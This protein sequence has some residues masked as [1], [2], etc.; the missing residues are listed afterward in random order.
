MRS[1]NSNG[2]AIL[3]MVTFVGVGCSASDPNARSRRANGSNRP[4]VAPDRV[5]LGSV[6]AGKTASKSISVSNPTTAP[7]DFQVEVDCDCLHVKPRVAV[8]QP[9]ETILLSIR[10]DS[11]E[12]PDFRGSLSI[13]VRG[14]DKRSREV[15][16]SKLDIIV[17]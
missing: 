16:R 2:W 5:D 6:A 17:K 8:V 9:G 12:A 11:T 7:V 1:G 13:G 14:R 4:L 10:Y 3:V 15:F